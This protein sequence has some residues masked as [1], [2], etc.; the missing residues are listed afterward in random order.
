MFIKTVDWQIERDSAG[1]QLTRY[2]G[3][4]NT[5]EC[6][7]YSLYAVPPCAKE[8]KSVIV[9]IAM[10]IAGQD[11]RKIIQIQTDRDGFETDVYALNN[12]GRTIDHFT[13]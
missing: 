1:K 11:H 7:S 9:E 5:Y 12:E 2:I 8:D 3:E 4:Q 10:T 6:D 13:Y